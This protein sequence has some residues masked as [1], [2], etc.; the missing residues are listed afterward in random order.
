MQRGLIQVLWRENWKHAAFL[1][2]SAQLEENDKVLKPL[3]KRNKQDCVQQWVS[4]IFFS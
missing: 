2:T 1:F 4:G 3:F